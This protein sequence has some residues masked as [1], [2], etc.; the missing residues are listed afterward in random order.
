MRLTVSATVVGVLVGLGGAQ[1]A[2]Q[3]PRAELQGVVDGRA[4][5]WHVVDLGSGNGSYWADMGTL[6]EI[7]V[8]AFPDADGLRLEGA[9]EFSLT[10]D[11][12]EDPMRVIG[13]QVTY[14]P[15]DGP[16]PFAVPPAA[17]A[18]VAVEMAAT[19]V[20]GGQI[21]LRGRLATP[22]QRVVDPAGSAFDAEDTI[23]IELDF[24]LSVDRL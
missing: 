15:E 21:R 3:E 24:D 7:T 18:R 23:E 6:H 17:Q 14:F 2:A 1:L 13:A 19:D 10:L 11:N 12:R 5:V 9:L 16:H 8:F 4:E 22:L 20:S